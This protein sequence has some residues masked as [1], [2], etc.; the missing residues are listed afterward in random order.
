MAAPWGLTTSS[1][2]GGLLTT[3]G[4]ASQ[5]STI[6]AFGDSYADNVGNYVYLLNGAG[7]TPVANGPSYIM[8][9]GTSLGYS[10]LSIGR[11][12]PPGG[13]TYPATRGTPVG[14]NYAIAGA[15]INGSQTLGTHPSSLMDQIG[16]FNLDY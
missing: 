7:Y 5:A 16:T 1:G 12:T 10:N 15:Q 14:T 8:N 2:S 11:Y 9:V 13:W 3:G 4:L 6:Y